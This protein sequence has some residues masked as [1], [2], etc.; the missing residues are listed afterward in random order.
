MYLS[1]RNKIRTWV[2]S[3]SVKD[4]N[5]QLLEIYILPVNLQEKKK[6]EREV[7]SQPPSGF[8]E[9]IS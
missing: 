2:W 7:V 3:V 9:F 4:S 1:A 8:F 6:R 5:S